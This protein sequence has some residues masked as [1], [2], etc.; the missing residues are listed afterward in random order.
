MLGLYLDPLFSSIRQ[1][2]CVTLPSIQTLHYL[3]QHRSFTLIQNHI[4]VT[5][6]LCASQMLGIVTYYFANA[7]KLWRSIFMIRTYWAKLV[8]TLVLPSS[9][10]PVQTN[11][12]QRYLHI[13]T[14]N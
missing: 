9:Y 14:S 2:P 11:M 6:S 5:P 1:S 7:Q 10:R 8:S 3:L 12:A 4:S 13:F